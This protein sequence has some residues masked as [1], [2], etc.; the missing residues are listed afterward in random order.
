MASLLVVPVAIVADIMI[1]VG[2]A[3]VGAMIAARTVDAEEVLD[4]CR[5][6]ARFARVFPVQTREIRALFSRHGGRTGGKQLSH[7]GREKMG[8]QRCPQCRRDN[9]EGTGSA[10]DRLVKAW[11]IARCQ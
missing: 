9:W 5:E 2:I 6:M 10:F 4:L 11:Q 7:G 1:I 3:V 8:Q